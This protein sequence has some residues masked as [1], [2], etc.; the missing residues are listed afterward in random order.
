MYDGR[1]RIVLIHRDYA[2]SGFAALRTPL[3]PFA[4]LE[5]ETRAVRAAR[6]PHDAALWAREVDRGRERM[7]RLLEIPAVREAIFLA[8]PSLDERIPVWL[9]DPDSDAGHGIEVGIVKYLSRMAA[10]CTPFGLFAGNTLGTIGRATRLEIQE[11]GA[12]VRHTRLDMDY[13]SEVVA[14][15]A[16][17]EAI[18]ERLAFVPNSSLGEVGGSLRYAEAR[19][20]GGRRSYFLVDVEPHEPLRRALARAEGG[21]SLE[22]IARAMVDEE[23]SF[24]AAREFAGQLADAQ[25]L[26]PE[27]GPVVTGPESLDALLSRLE[28]IAPAAAPR[29][30]LAQARETIVDLDAEGIGAAPSRYRALASSLAAITPVEPARLFQVDLTKPA[31]HVEVAEELLDELLR[32]AQALVDFFGHAR[33]DRLEPFRRAFEE[34]YGDREVPLVE[35]LDE[36]FGI[37]FEA[38]QGP[39]VDPSP[40]LAGLP[41]P[42]RE[43]L[44]KVGWGARGR[45][46]EWK[47]AEAVASG[48]EEMV[49]DPAEIAAFH[50]DA[51]PRLAGAIHVLASILESGD[52]AS[53]PRAVLD[54]AAGP[55]GARLLGRFCHGDPELRERVLEHL[56]AE[57]A[58]H[59]EVAF[60]EIVHLPEGRIGNILARPLLRELE[61]AFL[62]TSGAPRERT[63][64]IDDLTVRVSAN[65]VVLRSRRLGREVRP[66]LTTAHNTAWRSLGVYRFLAALQAE[67]I[68]EGV[69]WTWG[70]LESQP[71]LPRVRFGRLVLCRRMWNAR[72]AE[73]ARLLAGKGH[74]A[75]REAQAW[76]AERGLPRRVG[77]VDSD[78]VL[79]IDLDDPLSVAAFLDELRG[80]DTFTLQETL[81]G[82]RPDAVRAPEGRFVNE[83]V[84]PLVRRAAVGVPAAE[85]PIASRP[86]EAAANPLAGAPRSFLPGSSW[87][88]VKLYAGP[89]LADRLLLD[90]VAPVVT[91]MA[92]SSVI[93]RWF[94]VRYGDPD[95]HLRVRLNGDPARLLSE[96]LPA[97]SR[98]VEAPHRDGRL[99]RMQLDTYEREISRYGGGRGVVL[100]EELFHR[101]SIAALA[102]LERASG[103]AG[104][105]ARWRFAF[106]GMDRILSDLELADETKHEL[107]RR[108]AR[109]FGEEFGIDSG[110]RRKMMERYR[111]ERRAIEELLEG[112]GAGADAMAFA[113]PHLDARSAGARPACAALGRLAEQGALEAPMGEIAA[114][115]LHMHA[116]RVLRSANRAQEMV[117]YYYLENVYASR[118]ARRGAPQGRKVHA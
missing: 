91:S 38:A 60:F 26:V 35:A 29:A 100:C 2:P 30:I 37:G 101:D 105:D 53:A 36:E 97:F 106:A 23:I 46:L 61:L 47:L 67:G 74:G 103:D 107:V 34:R 93:E 51:G 68:V 116:N 43:E 19:L 3:L 48:A 32:G 40:L 45:W 96:A 11:S 41:F 73:V 118:A 18:R 88:T 115:L 21:A 92:E 70:P 110:L 71:R 9:A 83:V 85:A 14:R 59:P 86:A 44:E 7:R 89:A 55:S 72:K 69:Q 80:R 15:L 63:L 84:V 104:L 42:A 75:F 22:E 20:A 33:D 10:R 8:S 64:S 99:S 57:E 49:L 102:L 82:A 108:L 50:D 90:V 1:R 117:L 17:D 76:R 77:L 87:L 16:A 28:G 113:L 52:D 81:P 6:A 78:N 27:L 31:A 5:E 62:G 66:R 12:A 94:F 24:G 79:P 25:L 58:L 13:L 65:R 39:G 4:A 109:R 95:W 111:A 114:S 98:A 112:H 54:S 56:R